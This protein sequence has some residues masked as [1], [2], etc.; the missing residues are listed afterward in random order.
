MSA[1]EELNQLFQQYPQLRGKLRAIYLETLDPKLKPGTVD[2]PRNSRSGPRWT[3]QKGFE[4]G[5]RVLKAKLGSDSADQ[6][7]VRAFAAY[8]SGISDEN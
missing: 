8:V 6:E 7:D 1:R 5:L 4:D 3:E 2:R